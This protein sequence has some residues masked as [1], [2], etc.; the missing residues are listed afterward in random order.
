V[1]RLDPRRR[2]SG[3]RSTWAQRLHLAK[4]PARVLAQA[5]ALSAD[6]RPDDAVDLLTKARRRSD[7]VRIE[8]GL[9]E[10]RF[11]TFAGATP[12]AVLPPWPE[13]VSDLFPGAKIPEIGRG[14]LTPDR[15]RSAITHHGSLI[16]RGFASPTQVTRSVTNIERAFAAYDAIASEQP[17]PA[18]DGWFAPFKHDR[19]SNRPLKRAAGTM[20]AVDS[21]PAMCALIDTFEEAGVGRLMRDYF[22]ERP[23]LLGRKWSLRRV[24]HDANTG[25]WHQDGAFMGAGIRSLNIWL[26]LTHCGDTAP[27]IDVVGRRLD[28]IVE[29]GTGGAHFSWSVGNSVAQA[30]GLGSIVRPIFD[31]G[32]AMIFDHLCLHRTAIDPGMT[33]DRHAIE[34]WFLAPSTYGVMLGPGNADDAPQDQIPL[35]Y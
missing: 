34:A 31:A 19:V 3:T 23:A 5:A 21:P 25:D 15:L 6:G 16:I 33:I 12:P 28:R 7:D 18:L 22:G 35:A 17:E 2:S 24:E 20:L 10:A 11:Q 30:V 26:G 4:D 9:I 27:G 13:T 1:I 14:E 29:T 8:H 32:D